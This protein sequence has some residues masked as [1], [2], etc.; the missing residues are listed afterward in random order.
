MS[1]TPGPWHVVQ[2]FPYE[3]DLCIETEQGKPIVQTGQ[4]GDGG[5][6]NMAD[7]RLIAATPALL[8]ALEDAEAH[9]SDDFKRFEAPEDRALLR[10]IRAAIA[11]ARG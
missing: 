6:V 8:E 2:P 11:K 9:V 10:K 7:A 3:A 5:V 1:H 4:E